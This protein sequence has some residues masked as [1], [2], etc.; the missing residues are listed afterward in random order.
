LTAFGTTFIDSYDVIGH[1]HTKKSIDLGDE[2]IGKNWYHFLLENLLGGKKNMADIILGHMAAD[3]SIGIVF[4]D[5]SHV[6]GWESNRPYADILG[7][8]LGIGT[9]PEYFVFPVGAMFWAQV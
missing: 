8:Q 5:D 6:V 2:M 4:P 1:F 9:F 7:Q 3:S